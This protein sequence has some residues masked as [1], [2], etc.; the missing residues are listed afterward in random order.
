MCPACSHCLAFVGPLKTILFNCITKES[1]TNNN[2]NNNNNTTKPKNTSKSRNK[3]R[4]ESGKNKIHKA[5]NNN[6]SNNNNKKSSNSNSNDKDKDNDN[7]NNLSD[8]Y[9]AEKELPLLKECSPKTHNSD[10]IQCPDCK[11]GNSQLWIRI[12]NIDYRL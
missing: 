6:N 8:W 3:N 4:K 5:N 1:N 9:F 10:P 7:N 2:S 11:E 12:K